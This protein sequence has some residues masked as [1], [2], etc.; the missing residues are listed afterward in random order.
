LA[1]LW[2]LRGNLHFPRGELDACLAAHE[3]ALGFAEQAGSPEDIA[4]ALGGLGDAQYQRGRMLAA[5]DYFRRCV[6]L[7]DQHGLGGLRLTYLPML[8]GTQAYTDDFAGALELSTQAA[9]AARQAGDLRAELLAMNICASVENYRAR[10]SAAL[11]SSLRGLALARELGARRFEA[12]GLVLQGL[13]LFGLQ[14]HDAARAVLEEAVALSRIAAPTYCGPWALGALALASDDP[15]TSRRLLDEGAAL[16]ARGC[17]SHNHL[18][19]H[20]LAIEV[21]LRVGDRA[22]ALGYA[23]ALESYTREEPLAWASLVVARARVLAAGGRGR[24]ATARP[25]A[26]EVLDAARRMQFELL[27]PALLQPAAS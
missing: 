25:D 15:E 12:E 22:A 13:S 1:R 26:S 8:A 16:L 17:V 14:R 6:E 21:A 18:E 9:D 24:A 7:C 10:H 3:R 20:L 4:R 19:F 23:A 27:V 11:E 5:R 2:T